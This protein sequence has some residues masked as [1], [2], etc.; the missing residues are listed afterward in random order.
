MLLFRSEVAWTETSKKLD[1]KVEKSCKEKGKHGKSK[2]N[3]YFISLLCFA[4]GLRF[5]FREAL[6]NF[7]KML[8]KAVKAEW[9]RESGIL[10]KPTP[11]NTAS[12]TQ[13]RKKSTALVF[14][15]FFTISVLDSATK[16]QD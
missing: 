13:K 1:L 12:R 10:W 9:M 14:Q 6:L 5:L 16:A 3:K 7:N 4:R 15:P 2:V 11:N 8:V